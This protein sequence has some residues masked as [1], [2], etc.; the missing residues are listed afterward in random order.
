MVGGGFG[1]RCSALFAPGAEPPADALEVRRGRPRACSRR[2]DV[3]AVG[4]RTATDEVRADGQPRAGLG[5]L[6]GGASGLLPDS[7]LQPLGDVPDLEDLPGPPRR[8]TASRS[9]SSTAG[10]GRAWA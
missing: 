3:S 4:L 2:A 6:E 9:S 8:S 10:S 7:E 1:G 5:A